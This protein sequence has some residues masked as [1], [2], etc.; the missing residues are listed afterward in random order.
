MNIV[1]EIENGIL[2]EVQGNRSFKKVQP[3]QLSIAARREARAV[4]KSHEGDKT[5]PEVTELISEGAARMISSHEVEPQLDTIAELARQHR[6][7]K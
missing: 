5:T 6:V 2:E 3:Y 1:E 7:I 4:L